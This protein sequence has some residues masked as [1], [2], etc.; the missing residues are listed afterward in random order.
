MAKILRLFE[1]H[2]KLYTNFNYIA[3]ILVKR[4]ALMLK[5]RLY[6]TKYQLNK[7]ILMKPSIIFWELTQGC[8]L[9]CIHCRATAQP[10]R[11][12]EELSTMQAFD[13]IDTI[14]SYAKPLLILTGGEPLFRPD[15]FD[16][17]HYAISKGL[18]VAMASNGT[19]INEEISRK[20]KEIGIKRV[21]ISLDGPNP[22]I[23]DRFRGLEGSFEA[24][25]KG[26]SNLRDE[27][28]EIQFNTTIT[29]HNVNYLEEIVD[30]AYQQKV[31]ALHLFMLVPVGC[32]VQISESNMLDAKKYEEVLEWF[33]EQSRTAPFEF[34]ATCAPHYYRILRQKGKQTG[35]RVTSRPHGMNAMTKG[36]LA[37]T[38]V[39][40][41]SHR[42]DIQPC[43][44][45]PVTAGNILENSFQSIWKDSQLF[46]ELRDPANLNGK[47]GVCEYVNVC[48]GCRARAFYE[49]GNYLAEEPYC[50]HQPA[51]L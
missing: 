32:G 5:D 15:F 26:V 18:K 24:S 47:C 9:K 12:L 3:T 48:S 1:L 2:V 30:L 33:Y 39:C 34:R 13:V 42:G 4:G 14:S 40:F 37:G 16:I 44:Y 29:N 31:K 41:I 50:I 49:H 28:I 25:L 10:E 19:L 22:D 6:D 27:G 20:I 45:L 36:C 11:S 46:S 21:A 17:A 51:R 43:G 35:E 23:H 8:N 38:G 7:Q